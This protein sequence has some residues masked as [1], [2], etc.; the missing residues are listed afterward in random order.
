MKPV[1]LDLPYPSF[2]DLATDL[3]SA[4]I[5]SPAYAGLKGEL[6]ATL[7]YRFHNFYF[8]SYGY[9]ETSDLLAGISLAEMKHLDILGS[10]ILKLGYPPV[11]TTTVPSVRLYD[12]R[13]VV[14]GKDPQ[15]MLIS[16]INGELEAIS[17]YEEIICRLTNE[18]VVAV[19][20]R[21]KLDEEFHVKLLRGQLEKLNK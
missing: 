15:N 2:D 1:I 20:R 11:F 10:L 19:I 8:E 7:Q 5:I 18:R 3:Q 16:D 12:T 21:I 4:T 13:A 9:K 6:T 17:L 14:Y